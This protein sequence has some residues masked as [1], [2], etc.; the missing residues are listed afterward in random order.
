MKPRLR[1]S[2]RARRLR[3]QLTLRGEVEVVIPRGCSETTALAFAERHRNWIDRAQRR[4]K[5]RRLAPCLDGLRPQQIALTA[6]GQCWQV[7]YRASISGNPRE[8]GHTLIVDADSND[9]AIARLL[10]NWLQHKA[11]HHLIPWLQQTSEQLGLPFQRASIRNQKTRWGSCSCRGTIS[12]NRNVLFLPPELVR[13]LF[14]HELC[15]TRQLDHSARFWQLVS[16][17]EPDYRRLEQA[18]GNAIRLVP[19]WAL[20]E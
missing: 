16:H 3:L 8:Q 14:V 6:I 12:L 1:H 19:L 18:L 7:E 13:Y 5:Q 20:P 9:E 17:F 2:S 4:K 10:Q 11:R 15:H